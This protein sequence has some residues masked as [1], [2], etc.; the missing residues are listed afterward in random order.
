MARYLLSAWIHFGRAEVATGIISR[1]VG[2]D[3][4][5]RP[6]AWAKSRATA[7][8]SRSRKHFRLSL[9]ATHT[10][11]FGFTTDSIV[12]DAS[13]DNQRPARLSTGW[14]VLGTAKQKTG[15][16]AGPARGG[17]TI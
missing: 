2:R 14:R 10:L 3:R 6:N 15:G 8:W 7:R 13:V 9:N 17:A 12:R 4:A 16:R 1:P 5:E 11:I